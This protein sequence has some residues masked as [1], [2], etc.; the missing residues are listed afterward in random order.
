M[1]RF[2]LLFAGLMFLMIN[3]IVSQ[4]IVINEFM[5]S[6]TSTLQDSDGDFSDWIEIYNRGEAA[7]NLKG[8]MLSDD[9]LAPAK[10][11][12]PEMTFLPKT[13]IVIFASGKD[14]PDTTE[15]H[16]N[17]KIKNEGEYLLL[18]DSNGVRFDLMQP[19]ELSDDLSFGRFPDGWA[20][21]M[22]LG[23]PTPGN[24][25]NAGINVSFS[26]PAGFYKQPFKL[27][28]ETSNPFDTIF[29]TLD[30]S[31]PD[32]SSF[33]YSDSVPIYF[34]DTCPDYFSLI[35]T[36]PAKLKDYFRRW[37][38][39]N[40]PVAKANVVRAASY[41]NGEFRSPVLSATYFVDTAIFTE[42][43]Y[44]I[45]S[46]LTDSLNLFDFNTGIYVPGVF[47]DTL[48]TD[49]SGNYFQKGDEWERPAHLEY[50]EDSGN[51][52]LDL[53]VGLRMHGKITRHAPQ[54]TI[55]VYA[56]SEFGEGYFTYP[57]M[58]NSD[59]DK[60]KRFLIRSSYA[61][62]SQTFFKD[63]MTHDLVKDLNLDLMYY[64]P[65][66]VFINGEYWGT[67]IIRDRI[68]KYSLGLKYNIEPDSIDMLENNSEIEEGSNTDY[69]N[70]LEYIENNDL[71]DQEHYDSIKKRMDIENYIDY[72]IVEIYFNNND[73]PGSNIGYWRERA[74]GAKWRWI[75]FDLDNCYMDYAFNTLDFVTFEG[76]TCY[77]TL[78]WATFLFRNLLKSDEFKHQFIS[79]FD[80]LLKTTFQ[81]DTVLNQISIFTQQYEHDIDRHID[82]WQFP[83]SHQGWLDDI[84]FTLN[85]FARER[86]C[87]M[88]EFILNFFDLDE[89]DLAFTCSESI[90][91]IAEKRFVIAPNPASATFSLIIDGL[92]FTECQITIFDNLGRAI[93][94]KN[95]QTNNGSL[96]E[97]VDVSNFKTGIYLVNITDGIN[98]LTKKLIKT[99][100]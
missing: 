4:E 51:L 21:L 53:E 35:P 32:T 90:A 8:F 76:D 97:I 37:Y 41:L 78:T 100:N 95:I 40:G 94:K 28:I 45:V 77:Q 9:T 57:L 5:S 74:P 25:N 6:N 91:E 17:F 47:W 39:P 70:M 30:G 10:W 13:F 50:F 24:M 48:D 36:S 14:R 7:V 12:F 56:R 22:F 75:L 44:P 72:Q 87:Y 99:S 43:K 86:P 92:D 66:T 93:F 68:D 83:R 61:D 64:R 58:I 54:K 11:R 82:R 49:F 52:A 60:F 89:D 55:R 33:M 59:Q 34:R 3:T 46:I 85:S 1:K 27:A 81:R 98:I 80:S 42:T 15:L 31:I 26:M 71:S 62:G 67:Q 18:S 29:Y 69:L 84:N 20:G 23:T 65:V 96:N 16:T 88:R 63:E 19:V 73:W 79:R 2:A 38:P